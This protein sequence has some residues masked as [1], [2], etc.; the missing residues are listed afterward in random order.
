MTGN[1]KTRLGESSKKKLK[2]GFF[3]KDAAE[4]GSGRDSL[5]E[6]GKKKLVRKGGIGCEHI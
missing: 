2:K 5:K 3:V 1:S 4:V 6:P